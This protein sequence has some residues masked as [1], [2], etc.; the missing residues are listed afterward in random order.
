MRKTLFIYITQL[1]AEPAGWLLRD[2]TGSSSQV[3]SQQPGWP[4]AHIAKNNRVVVILGSEYCLCTTAQFPGRKNLNAW[5]KAAPWILEDQLAED[6]SQLHYAIAPE[7]G[8]DGKYLVAASKQEPLEQLLQSLEE[9]QLDVDSITPDASLLPT[10]TEQPELSAKLGD[11]IL[12]KNQDSAC[13]LPSMAAEAI[14]SNESHWLTSDGPL[15]ALDALSAEWHAEHSLNLRQ[16]PL[17]QGE[18][19]VARL[20]PWRLPALA[21][22]VTALM[23]TAATSL[24]VSELKR[25]NQRLKEEIAS[26]FKQALPG[27][28]MVKPRTQMEQALR[29][30]QG[31]TQSGFLLALETA[32]KPL[33]AIPDAKLKSLDQRGSSLVL[34]LQASQ[35][36]TVDQVRTAM[37]QL[38]GYRAE[39]GSV[40]ADT[41]TVQLRVTIRP[42]AS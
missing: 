22:V 15:A 5:R 21:A 7:A 33:Q 10:S 29:G 28:K 32:T 13:A 34:N 16:G 38:P 31:A 17:A 6:S 20:R 3:E 35:I 37:S 41:D 9:Q 4:P 23:W 19:I 42:A 36:S 30:N 27:A 1:G 39:V 8:A 14:L 12:L 2:N 26:V 40:R 24:H 18:A 11:R 25:E